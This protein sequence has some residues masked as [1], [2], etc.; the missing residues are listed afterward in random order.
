MRPRRRDQGGG[1]ALV[2][3]EPGDLVSI[4]LSLCSCHRGTGFGGDG[5]RNEKIVL[6]A[7][8][9]IFNSFTICLGSYMAGLT[10]SA[11]GDG[12]GALH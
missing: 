12:S 7:G 1:N 9:K 5:F 10:T 11:R 2:R 6:E 8:P 4:V 3:N